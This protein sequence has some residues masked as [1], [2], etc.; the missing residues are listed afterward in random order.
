MWSNKARPDRRL[1]CLECSRAPPVETQ[2]CAVCSA[3]KTKSEFGTSMWMHK[4]RPDRR[5]VCLE[6]SR[7][8][9]TAKNCTTCQV[10]RDPDCRKRK[11]NKP[12]TS[13]NAKLMPQSLEEVR[14]FLCSTCRKTTCRCG[15]AMPPSRVKKLKA[16]NK[17][18]DVYVCLDCLQH[19]QS[20]AD[21]KHK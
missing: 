16:Q 18:E 21:A 13:L 11:C 1:V 20:V 14:T 17:L 12:L 5:L 19:Q 4:A 7:P 8:R 9:C 2:A 3:Q 6:C 10:C 15:K